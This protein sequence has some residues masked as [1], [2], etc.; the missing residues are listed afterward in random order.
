MVYALAR[1]VAAAY[2]DTLRDKEGRRLFDIYRRDGG[3]LTDEFRVA[4]GVR[5]QTTTG[6]QTYEF[7]TQGE[8][9]GRDVMSVDLQLALCDR[10][11]LPT[12]LRE[13]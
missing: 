12:K 10:Q 8:H 6:Q 9:D 4:D 1:C 2:T 5:T 7:A 13:G 3:R 11:G